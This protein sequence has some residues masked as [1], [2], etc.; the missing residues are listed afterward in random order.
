MG[1]SQSELQM[2]RLTE[3]GAG[4]TI[5]SQNLTACVDCISFSE[6]KVLPCAVLLVGLIYTAVA[7]T[8]YFE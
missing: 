5:V 3:V 8:F 1:L 7:A 6:K 2:D 4:D